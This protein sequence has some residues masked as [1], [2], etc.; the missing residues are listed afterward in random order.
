MFLPWA[1]ALLAANAGPA[2][3]GDLP[4]GFVRLADLA[5]TIRQDMR[6]AGP[7]NVTGHPLAGYAGPA[8]ILRTEAAQA[9]A[10]VQRDL[11]PEGLGLV[12]FD[13]YRP[14]RA[15]ADLLAWARAGDGP[16]RAPDHP[17]VDR[18]A[19]VA[20]GYIA[21]RSVHSTGYAVDL[22]LARLGAPASP[23]QAGA[24]CTAP[25]ARRGDRGLIDFGTGF[26]C[27][28]PK[29]WTAASGLPAEAARNRRRLV[30]AMRAEGFANYPR[31]WWHFGY[32]GHAGAAAE[33]FPV[34]AP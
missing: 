16:Q 10:A 24:P 13:C 21:A 19:L 31:E 20:L 15:V 23:G 33:D 28:D 8:C 17:A 11:A 1:A 14:Q 26:D 29:S 9:L 12:V 2:G 34:T 27:F 4:A 5:P 30:A 32:D 7:D 18:R 25:V 22:G 6:Y 3:A